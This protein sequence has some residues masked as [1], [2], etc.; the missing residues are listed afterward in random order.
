MPT[1][2]SAGARAPLEPAV[3]AAAVAF[4]SLTLVE[5]CAPPP[6]FVFIKIIRKNTKVI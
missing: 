1:P 5:H 6:F 3:L 2:A 4:S